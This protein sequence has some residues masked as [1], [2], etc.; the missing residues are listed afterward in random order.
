MRRLLPALAVFVLLFTGC[1]TH[2]AGASG[3]PDPSPTTCTPPAGGRCAGDVAWRGPISLASDGRTLYGTV[4][5]GGTLHATESPDRVD[6]L[7][8]VGAVPRG[9]MTC[10]RV[11][12][13]VRLSEPLG[14]RPVYDAVTGARITVLGEHG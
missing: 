3:T 13:A 10:A 9:G 14:S 6:L 5:C 2:G 12:T 1:G 11:K 8:H 7:L 4:I